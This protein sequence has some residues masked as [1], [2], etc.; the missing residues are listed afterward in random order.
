MTDEER[1]LDV[2]NA[3]DT[4]NENEKTILC[5]RRRLERASTAIRALLMNPGDDDALNVMAQVGND[6]HNATH[7]ARLTREQDQLKVF[8]TRQGYS[9]LMRG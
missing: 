4:F 8:L 6:A 7:L 3:L 9:G 2:K 1:A 5:L